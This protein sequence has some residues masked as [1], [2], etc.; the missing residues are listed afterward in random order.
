[1]NIGQLSAASGVS[2]KM[3]RHYEAIGLIPKPPRSDAGYRR[4]QQNDVQLLIFVR[5]ARAV[6]F[7]TTEI[8]SLVAMWLDRRRSA[9]EVMA[10]A[11]RH[12]ATV[13]ARI[14]ELKVIARTISHLVQHCHGGDRPECPILDALADGGAGGQKEKVVRV[15]ASHRQ[16]PRRS[17]G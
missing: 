10:V 14:D 11:E 2:A 6:G 7:A 3:I 1:M 17:K 8:K 16:L 9:R 5:R 4:Y 12:L 13:E 15:A